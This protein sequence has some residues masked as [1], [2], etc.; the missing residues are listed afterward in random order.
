M[1]KLSSEFEKKGYKIQKLLDVKFIKNTQKLIKSSKHTKNIKQNIFDIE[2]LKLQS[3]LFQN[4][5]HLKIIH[6][7]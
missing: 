6:N 4:S 7:E 1:N 3:K 2:A 5:I